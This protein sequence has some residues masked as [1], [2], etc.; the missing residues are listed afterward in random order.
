MKP[1]VYYWEFVNI[2]RKVILV[3][4]NVMF[5]TTGD[6]FKAIICLLALVII[7]RIKEKLQP[8]KSDLL[9]RVE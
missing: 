1:S 9:N 6:M 3:A 2:I 7:F 8:Y 5:T 4:A